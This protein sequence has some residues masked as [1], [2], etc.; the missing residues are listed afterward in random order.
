VLVAPTACGVPGPGRSSRAWSLV[1][2]AALV[3]VVALGAA[4]WTGQAPFG[5]DNDEYQLVARQLLELEGPVVAGVEGTKYPLGYPALLAALDA[6]GL[7]MVDTALSLNVV[8]VGVTA[9][10]AALAA[11]HLGPVA[12]VVAAGVVVASRPLWAATQ[13]TMP[14]VALT[15]VVAIAVVWAAH[16]R[17]L[18]M[19]TGLAVAAAALKSV[20]LL[21]GVAATVALLAQRRPWRQALLPAAAAGAITVAMTALTARYPEHTTGYARTFFL[22]DPYD[23]T[24][25][26]ASL[27]DVAARVGTRMDAVLDDA[28][29]AVWGDLVHGVV[30]WVLTL[31]LVAA[32]VAGARA[33]ARPLVAAFVVVDL[34]ALAVWPYSSVRFGLPLVPIA[35]LG[36]AWLVSVVARPVP[37]RLGAAVASVGV[38]AVAAAAVPTLRDEAHREG[39]LYAGL[40][41]ARA[42]VAVWLDAN[43]PAGSSTLV[44]PDYRELAL[45]LERPVLPLPYTRTPDELLAAAARGTH[46]VVAR[47]LYGS[48]EVVIGTLLDAHG[49]RFELVHQNERFDV[50]ALAR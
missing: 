38:V 43:A 30:G 31:A 32:G 37:P 14:D 35:A 21:L 47:G 5:S 29:K 23:A 4:R 45:E 17:P 20:G 10:G 44:S 34:L 22:D 8:L 39:E 9:A 7:P 26:E 2:L 6:V 46:L 42:E 16:R 11:R 12:A 25:G 48:R 24:G 33:A 18:A 50:Y 27:V 3:V 40:H 49:G 1:G 13:S 19:L 36:A 41:R 28:T 15:T